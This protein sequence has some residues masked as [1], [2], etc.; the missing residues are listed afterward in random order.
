MIIDTSVVIAILRME[1]DASRYA[2]ALQEAAT[3]AISAANVLEAHLVIG[4][5][6]A[7][8]LDD[9]MSASGAEVVAVDSEQLRIA[10]AAHDRFGR[11][12]GSPARL[13]LGDCFAYAL[14]RATNQPLLFNGEE[15]R[16]TDVL[17][18]LGP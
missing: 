12:S 1:P 7:G 6:R 18:A 3:V 4:A 17:P 14:A 16:H 10:R 13:N 15:F 2:G 11:G 8:D 9:L 5:T